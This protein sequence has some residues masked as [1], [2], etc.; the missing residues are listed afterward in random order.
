MKWLLVCFPSVWVHSKIVRL[1][2]EDTDFSFILQ[3]GVFPLTWENRM[4]KYSKKRNLIQNER[5]YTTGTIESY[6]CM[7]SSLLYVLSFKPSAISN[8]LYSWTVVNHTETRRHSQ[9]RAE[10]ILRP[11][12]LHYN[13]FVNDTIVFFEI[14]FYH[15]LFLIGKTKISTNV[16]IVLYNIYCM[17]N[18]RFISSLLNS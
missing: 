5:F 2:F 11:R 12:D 4:Y 7:H 16:R 3:T 13:Q 15:I 17:A 9:N 18:M 10:N 1:L 6:T 14:M 8:T